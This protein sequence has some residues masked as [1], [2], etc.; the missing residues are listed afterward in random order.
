VNAAPGTLACHPVNP[1]CK[2][3][4]RVRAAMKPATGFFMFALIHSAAA[5]SAPPP[6]SPIMITPWVSGS[7]L[8]RVRTSMKSRPPTGSAEDGLRRSIVDYTSGFGGDGSGE[9]AARNVELWIKK[10]E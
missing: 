7:W 1:R 10:P 2:C 6:I 3:V 4:N 8:N 9:A 5:I